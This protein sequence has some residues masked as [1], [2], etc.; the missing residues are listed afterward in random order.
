MRNLVVGNEFSRDDMSVI[1]HFIRR[2]S[3]AL[4]PAA[5]A[6]LF[7]ATPVLAQERVTGTISGTV[8]DAESGEPLVAAFVRLVELHRSEPSHA[9][10]SFA[11]L[12]V[13][14]GTYQLTVERLGYRTAIEEVTVVAGRGTAV[15]IPLSV[16]AIQLGEIVVT[17][18]IGAREGRDVLSP[19]AVL[20]GAEMD[21]RLE[22]TVAGTL[23]NEPGVAVTGIGPSTSR[24]VIRGLGG[25]RILVLEDGQRP[26]DM[27]STSADHAVA[28][29]PMTAKQFEVVRGPMSLLY[30]SSALGGVVNVVRDEVPDAI[31]DDEVHGSATLQAS[32]V[33]AGYAAGGYAT[34][35]L[36]S[37]IAVRGEAS[38]RSND[39]VATPLGTLSNTELRT[40]NASAGLAVVGQDG[41]VGAAYRFYD[42]EYG[43]PGGFVGGHEA[44]V[45]VDMLRHTLRLQ[46]ELHREEALFSRV[47]VDGQY[48]DYQHSELESSGEIGTQFFQ[49]LLTAELQARHGPYRRLTEGALGARVQYRDIVTAGSLRTPSTYDL[50]LAGYAVEELGRGDFRLQ[51]GARFDY[52]RYVPRDTSAF[53]FIGGERV[54]VRER[55]FGALSGSF[56]LLYTVSDIV[57]VGSSISRAYRTPDFNE[58]Y[59]NGP[60]LAANSFDVGDPDLD[61][62]TG[63]G[64]DAF[65]RVTAERLRAEV[66]I[67][68]NYLDEYIFPSSRGRAETGPQAGRP[69]FQYTNQDARFTGAEGD[70]EWNAV[71]NIVVG[72]TL[73]YVRAQF[74]SRRDSI[75]VFE[76]VDTAFVPASQHPPFIPPLNGRVGVRYEEPGHFVGVEARYAADQERLGDFETRTDGYTIANLDAGVRIERGGR[77]HSV[78]LRV[79]NLT[80]ASYRDHLSR[81]K[82]IRPQPGRN[83]SLLYRVSF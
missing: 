19:V 25:D 51:L 38:F 11:F 20:S 42:N 2:G 53:I 65:V 57:R 3:R 67:F 40:I 72:T 4:A 22:A 68:R 71:G 49:D 63:L 60:H 9:D 1:M 13:P 52:A 32:S 80:D 79:D 69:R 45:D 10:G 12:N 47:Q 5:A 35:A 66:A 58:L 46:A 7:G 27:S 76:G 50:A 24:P 6:L 75:P 81:I 15:R 70:L 64:L 56:G 31:G 59:S 73:S 78:T 43:I 48:S 44:G 62:E 33:D 36:G 34:T 54:P 82:D 23:E 83:F 41:H 17:G 28:I 14:P 16:A 39:D 37:S 21:R 74:T 30:G 18:T 8:V 61:Q 55:T 77:L 26:G 29:E